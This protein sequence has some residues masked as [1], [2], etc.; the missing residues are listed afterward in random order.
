MKRT[1]IAVALA[2]VAA[3]GS[4]HAQ[5]G[6]DPRGDATISRADEQKRAEERFAAADTDH[7]GFISAKEQS[8][9]RGQGQ[10][11]PG[12]G[13]RGADSDGDGKISKDEFVST[14]LQRFDAQDTDKDG[15]LTKAERDAAWAQR[16]Q[17]GFGFGPPSGTE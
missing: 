14:R 16:M 10:R 15:Q 4:A 17:S 9:A 2:T 3:G 8:A 7:D 5:P 6:P 1:M 12:G 11:G 13:M